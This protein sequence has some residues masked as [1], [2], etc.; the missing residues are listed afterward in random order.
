MR[1]RRVAIFL[2]FLVGLLILFSAVA[3]PSPAYAS[4][5][6]EYDYVD[7]NISNVDGISDIGTHSNFTAQQYGPDSIYDTLIEENTGGGGSIVLESYS[8]YESTAGATSHTVDKPTGTVDDDLLIAIL[9]TDGAGETLTA[10]SGWTAIFDTIDTQASA[11]RVWYKIASSE[12]ASYTFT[13][14]SSESCVLAVLRLS[15]HDLT[16]PIDVNGTDTQANTSP[17]TCPSVTTTVS[18]AWI[19][20]CFG[21]DDGDVTEDSGYPSGHTGIFVR[22]SDESWGEG[23]CG[24]AYTTQALPG[25]TG[26]AD[27]TPTAAEQWAAATVALKP[28][29]V[30]YELDLEVQWTNATYV[31]PNEELCIFGGTM[32]SEDVQ[33]DVWNGSTWHNLFTDLSSGWNNVSVTDYLVSSTF[34]IRFKGGTE[35]GDTSQ[36]SWE[37]DCTLL[38][39]WGAAPTANFSYTPEY[40]YT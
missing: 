21:A 36:D 29:A 27:F 19:L 12:P 13:V 15:G 38:H 20:R 3:S 31:M 18:N 30:N 37:I 34:T 11:F 40:P 6:R 16:N 24:A 23:S 17:Y 14:T 25:A 5:A 39:T 10:P 7:N 26:N 32:G 9:N 28:S 35:T 22:K 1:E 4:P 2:L 8:I 33:V